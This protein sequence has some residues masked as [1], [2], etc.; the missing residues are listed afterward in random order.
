M[1]L[2]NII[3]NSLPIALIAIGL[4]FTQCVKDERNLG[5]QT[6]PD[7][8]KLKI[9]STKIYLPLQTKVFQDFQGISSTTGYVGA[10]RSEQNGLATFSFGVNYCPNSLK[11]NFGQSPI[12]KKCF[13]TFVKGNT[14]VADKSQENILQNFHIYR[15]KR[16]IDTFHIYNSGLTDEDYYPTSIEDGGLFYTGGDTLRVFLKDSFAENLLNAS[17]WAL[18]STN[19]F[20]QEFGGLL[21]TCDP[22]I[23][24]GGR[25]N[26]FTVSN[27]NIQLQVNFQP[28][29]KSG[30]ERKDTTFLFVLGV[31]D[32]QNFSSYES[33]GQ[34]SE[35]F[36]EYVNVEGIAGIK[37]YVNPL[38]LKDSIDK[39]LTANSI[40]KNKFIVARARYYL[41][42]TNPTDPTD[43]NNYYPGYLYP[44]YKYVRDDLYHKYLPLADV[45]EEENNHGL[46]NRSLGYYYGDMSSWLQRFILK[47]KSEIEPNG[48]Y[49]LWFAP[50]SAITSSSYY[51][52][53]SITT[54][55]ANSDSYVLGK[56]NG[57]RHA[58][59]P[60][61]EIIYTILPD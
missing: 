1:H 54:Y 30:L 43:I 46:L 22:P 31:N 57:P 20:L 55:S 28:T 32:I 58:N 29:W 2:K 53:S 49:A 12:V 23:G 6:I 14:S 16:Q 52:S 56:I 9:G 40:D 50:L 15:M 35:D 59:P 21:F 39:F 4:L 25:L 27:A 19:H 37:P 13:I 36:T 48:E 41:P 5:E 61:I 7:D 51:S 60:Y 47:D 44:C 42:I 10:I 17:Q 33:E 26:G 3:K 18:D 45:D 24:N 38:N 8:Y 34:Q 11:F